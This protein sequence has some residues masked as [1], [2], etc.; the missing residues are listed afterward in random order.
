[1]VY[2]LR[3]VLFIWVATLIYLVHMLWCIVCISVFFDKSLVGQV[4]FVAEACLARVFED[5]YTYHIAYC[6]HREVLAYRWQHLFVSAKWYIYIYIYELY[7][8]WRLSIV[9][10]FAFIQTYV[11]HHCPYVYL[12]SVTVTMFLWDYSILSYS[13]YLDQVGSWVRFPHPET[14]ITQ[15]RDTIYWM[16]NN[17][18]TA[19]SAFYMSGNTYLISTYVVVYTWGL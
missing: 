19:T 4:T 7:V 14:W 2:I 18:Y 1:M 16:R 9:V 12:F 10:I 17:I 13:I 11:S 8:L 3:P 15:R 6:M 5:G